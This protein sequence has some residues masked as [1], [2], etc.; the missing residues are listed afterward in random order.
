VAPGLTRR[1]GALPAEVTGFVGRD[2]E[3]RQLAGLLQCV[4]LVT[5][6]GP[7]GVGKTRVALR[8]A[9]AAAHRYS[10]GVYLAE[11]SGL[12]DAALL[13]H[14][15]AASLG[16]PQSAAQLETVL[17]FL[18]DRELLLILDTCEHL[19][20]AC[21]ML[22]DAVLRAGPGVSVLATSRQP[23]DVPGENPLVLAPLPAHDAV[24]LFA[25]RAAAVAEGFAVT[26]GNQ[27]DVARLCRRLDGIPLAIEL[28]AVRLRALPLPV[29]ADR[30]EH[31][32]GVLDSGLRTSV[33]RHRTIRTAVEWSHET[34]TPAEQAL[35]ARL[36]VFAGSFCLTV[37]E[38][39]CTDSV[40]DREEV[41]AALIGLVDK[42]VLL[43]SESGDQTRYRLL[44]TLREF[45]AAQL[46]ACGQEEEFRTRLIARYLAMTAYFEEHHLD[47]QLPLYREIRRE[48]P[49]IRAG[50]EYAL[51]LPHQHGAAARLVTNL[52]DYWRMTDQEAE[53][54]YWLQKILD[55]FPGACPERAAALT[56]WC[57]VYTWAQ[58]GLEGIAIAKQLGEERI[59]ARGYLYLASTLSFAG[60]LGSA[61][62]AGARAQERLEAL[63]DR[64]ALIMLDSELA[65]LH[66]YSGELDQALERCEQ[67][68]RRVAGRGDVWLTAG[69]YRTKGL[70]LFRQGKHEAS[71]EA[72]STALP[73][74]AKLAELG[75][76]FGVTTCLETISWLAAGQQ[77]HQRAAWLL[78][79]AGAAMDSS[80]LG[81]SDLPD[82]IKEKHQ[83]TEEAVRGTLGPVRYTA[84]FR[85]GYEYPLDQLIQHVVGDRD[86]LPEQ[87]AV[88]PRAPGADPLTRREREIAALVAS[89]LTNRDIASRLV[90]SKRTVDAHVDHIYAKLGISS[91]I[92]L[93]NLLKP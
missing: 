62:W 92:Q 26:A 87:A 53:A 81:F 3:L 24:N 55:V 59:A 28:A 63:G 10:G 13:P 22:A 12:R 40:L 27:A 11:L 77:R 7:G 73:L 82:E 85:M 16:L 90:V 76:Y 38:E 91:R 78:G 23:L 72:F 33:P 70:A 75:N 93:A 20:D 71:A 86:D 8:A 1:A 36:S 9:S 31:R 50:I 5:V 64:D 84:F 34:C 45:G 39:V 21:A 69:L 61:R 74:Y 68:L 47:D 48:H 52:A 54:R 65:E 60:L 18:R 41:T 42:S 30:V 66:S 83:Q 88:S 4:R 32:F 14:A 2:A 49:N 46:A 58:A 25:Q 57:H 79:A 19:L 17:N 67:G 35:W 44:D 6:T 51:A 89:G 15:V 56:V 43:R 37:A 80:R 29:L